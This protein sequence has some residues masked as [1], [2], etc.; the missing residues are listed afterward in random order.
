VQVAHVTVGEGVAPLVLRAALE[1]A[2]E[3]PVLRDEGLTSRDRLAPGVAGRTGPQ[4]QPPCP[5]CRPLRAA[6]IIP[7]PQ[8]SPRCLPPFL[9]LAVTW[10]SR[11]IR[12]ALGRQWMR[13]AAEPGD[14]KPSLRKPG[15]LLLPLRRPSL[16]HPRP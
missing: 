13:G 9:S 10:S 16:S 7:R 15:L 5:T 3:D 2:E 8:T 14:L 11:W 12:R 6:P 1:R 4:P